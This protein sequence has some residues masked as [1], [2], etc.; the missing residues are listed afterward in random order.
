MEG[1]LKVDRKGVS[2]SY[3]AS[4]VFFLIISIHENNETRSAIRKF[5][6][7]RFCVVDN[8]LFQSFFGEL[9]R[10]YRNL[11]SQAFNSSKEESSSQRAISSKSFFFPKAYLAGVPMEKS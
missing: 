11:E 5:H 4:G 7:P 3:G 10:T 2:A 9:Y 6:G 8:S 1:C